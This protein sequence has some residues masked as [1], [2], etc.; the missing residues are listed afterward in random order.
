M[1]RN[2]VGKAGPKEFFK[3]VNI[4][5]SAGLPQFWLLM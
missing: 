3:W 4:E 1:R 5:P 2:L